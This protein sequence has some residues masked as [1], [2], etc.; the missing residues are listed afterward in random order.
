M[1][2]RRPPPRPPKMWPFHILREIRDGIITLQTGQTKMTQALDDLTAAVSNLTAAV[3]DSANEISSLASQ[4]AAAGDDA[5][6][7]ALVGK[8]NDETNALKSAVSAVSAV[9]PAPATDTVDANA[10]ADTTDGG[11]V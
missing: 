5:E 10:G 2:S 6:I 3:T 8:I 7:E 4:I 11:A 1:P 9:Q